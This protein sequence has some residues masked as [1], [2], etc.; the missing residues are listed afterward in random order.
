MF[1]RWGAFVYRFR[2]PIAILAVVL[3]VAST[4]LASQVTGALSAGGWT[5][6][7]SESAAVAQRLED[8]F[9]AGGGADRRPVPGHAPATTPAPTSSRPRSPHRSTGWSPTT[10][11]TAPSAGRRPATTGSSARTGRP[12]TW[13]SASAS[14]T[15][16][17]STR[18][19]SCATLI[20]Q[21]AGSDP[22]AD[23]RGAGDPG[24]GRAVREG[25]RP[26]R[27]GLVPVRRAHPRPRLRLARR[28]RHAARRRRRWP[29]RRRSPASTSPPR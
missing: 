23:R 7:D 25:A 16:P 11:S 28:G 3:A 8:E 5:D 14:P 4:S 20:D 13:S 17:R 12:P 21:P 1:R 15:R 6:P 10:A 9:G 2:R 24:P 18:C 26:G 19:T 29:S 27:D 22:P